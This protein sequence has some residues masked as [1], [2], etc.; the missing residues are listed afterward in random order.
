MER[1]IWNVDGEIDMGLGSSIDSLCTILIDDPYFNTIC[2]GGNLKEYD[3]RY[4]IFSLDGVRNKFHC[5]LNNL[6]ISIKLKRDQF[7]DTEPIIIFKKDKTLQ[8]TIN[9]T[10][11]DDHTSYMY[12]STDNLKSLSLKM[13]GKNIYQIMVAMFIESSFLIIQKKKLF[14][15]LIKAFIK[16]N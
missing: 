2:Y 14:S 9:N 13:N 4:E 6:N 16:I 12:I 15:Y 11:K 5:R 10:S 3:D 8:M 1:G 7:S